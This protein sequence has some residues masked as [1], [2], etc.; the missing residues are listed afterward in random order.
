[1][2]DMQVGE[3]CTLS[4][5]YSETELSIAN[6]FGVPFRPPIHYVMLHYPSDKS[7]FRFFFALDANNCV[8]V[9][10]VYLLY[11]LVSC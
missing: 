6:F 3:L 2:L 11:F 5:C 8:I 9:L 7:D 4:A 10:L 1:M